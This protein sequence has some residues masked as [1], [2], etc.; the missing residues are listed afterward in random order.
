MAVV[1]RSDLWAGLDIKS[2]GGMRGYWDGRNWSFSVRLKGGVEGREVDYMLHPWTGE[3][4][5]AFLTCFYLHDRGLF[6]H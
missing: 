3:L 1:A 6:H 5:T 2:R 4:A